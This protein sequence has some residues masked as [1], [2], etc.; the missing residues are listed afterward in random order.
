[1]MLLLLGALA[2]QAPPTSPSG[3]GPAAS[4]AVSKRWPTRE[5]DVVLKDFRFRDG[6][7]LPQ[8]WIPRLGSRIAMPQVR[9]TMR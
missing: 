3:W 9:S 6:E 5:G 8:V 4:A 1:M 2:L 7:F